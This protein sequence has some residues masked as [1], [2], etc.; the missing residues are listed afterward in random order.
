MSQVSVPQLLVG[1]NESSS[2]I[3][4]DSQFTT[5]K[6]T[7]TGDDSG[8]ALQITSTNANSILTLGG[9][10]VTGATQ[11]TNTD[12]VVID[13][14]TRE[15]S[16][17]FE[18]DGGLVVR[19]K[20]DV[21]G[22]ACFQGTIFN[23]DISTKNNL[24][25]QANLA[26]LDVLY[27][28]RIYCVNMS[29]YTNPEDLENNPNTKVVDGG[30]AILDIL[31][32][33]H[34]YCPNVEVLESESL[35]MDLC[36]DSDLSTVMHYY[37]GANFTGKYVIIDELHC[38]TL[39][40][41]AV[42]CVRGRPMDSGFGG[43][44]NSSAGSILGTRTY[45]GGVQAND[46]WRF[47]IDTDPQSPYY[48]RLLFQRFNGELDGYE[49]PSM[50]YRVWMSHR[51]FDTINGSWSIVRGITGNG[52]VYFVE[53][54]ANTE[55]TYLTTDCTTIMRGAVSDGY[56]I[57]RLYVSYEILTADLTSISAVVVKKTFDRDTPSD[58]I[59]ISNI[60]ISGGNLTSGNVIGDHHRYIE[61]TDLTRTGTNHST[62][63]IEI[64]I[65]SPATSV[66]RFHGCFLEYEKWEMTGY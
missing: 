2:L 46:T 15:R 22:D 48:L 26:V 30:N 50:N 64:T 16:G 8:V 17:A 58:A 5:K 45:I 24:V 36:G 60:P 39:Y 34:L 18:I 40:C 44:S 43:Y 37:R 7:L 3:R 12:D 23:E 14:A 21:K 56:Q 51:D 13:P 33:G 4:S 10:N 31:I 29:T 59:T 32:V 9:M 65:V 1:P 27:A 28:K 41:P 6:V 53:K 54:A 66:V 49:N 61:I 42:F 55:T 57:N 47:S 52:A 35:E 62:T 63:Q 25:S 11:Y 19:K 38:T 20:I